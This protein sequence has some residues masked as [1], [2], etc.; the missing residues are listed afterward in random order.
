M[1]TWALI[2]RICQEMLRDKRTLALL[3]LAPILILSLM[4][5][6]F[7]GNSVDPKLAVVNIDN[8]MVNALEKA[9]VDAIEY[10]KANKATIVD[11]NL[12]GLLQLKNGN[13]DLTLL[14]SNPSTAKVLLMKV[15]Q[16]VALQAQ[17]LPIEQKASK[18]DSMKKV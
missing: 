17:S 10:D 4:Y 11:D 13:F 15:N 18:V 2:K 8:R 7:N 16:S 12:D 9:N 14:N 5:F 1:R 6:I 3:F